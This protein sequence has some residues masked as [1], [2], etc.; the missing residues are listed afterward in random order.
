M[1]TLIK[2]SNGVYYAILSDPSGRRKWISTGERKLAKALERLSS[3][4]N[5]LSERP[6]SPKLSKFYSEFI[7]YARTVYSKETIGIY[8]RSLDNLMRITGDISLSMIDQRHVD[9]FKSR[10]LSEIKSVTVNIE[11]RTLRAAFFTALR[12]KLMDENPFKQVKLC[13]LDE[14]PPQ[15]LTVGEFQSLLA[16]IDAD[17]LRDLVV[18]AVLTGM[19]RGE[20]LNLQWTCVDLNRR[21]IRIQSQ[22]DFRTKLGKRRSIPINAQIVPIFERR[23][24]LR[25]GDFVFHDDGYRLN[26]RR[27]TAFFKRCVRRAGLNDDLHFHSLRHSFASWLVQGNVSLYQVQ[28]LLGHS[29]IRVTEIYSHLLPETMHETVDRLQI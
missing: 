25:N 4:Q 17:W 7:D 13:Q 14:I 2:R 26:E 28:K 12:W 10:R 20:L 9:F 29:N 1:P 5:P 3:I 15:F 16:I 19:R 21:I 6:Q 18:V 22:G 8:R 27:V 24:V 23:L 11:L